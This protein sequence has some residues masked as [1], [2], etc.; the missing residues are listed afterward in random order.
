MDSVKIIVTKPTGEEQG[1]LTDSAK[2]DVDIGD[3]CDF[4]IEIDNG[5]WNEEKH[6]YG[7]RFFVPDTE[8]GGIIKSI[9]SITK[10][11]K[12]TLSGYTWRGPPSAFG[13]SKRDNRTID[14]RQIRKFICNGFCKNR[15][16]GK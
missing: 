8:Y 1:N 9:K 2:V 13:G 12:I 5:E 4:E 10:T 11:E 15:N 7:C 14:W 6:G 16:R 3:K